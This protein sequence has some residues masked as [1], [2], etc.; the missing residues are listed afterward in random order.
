MVSCLRLIVSWAT[1][2]LIGTDLFV[3]SPLIPLIADD[4]QVGIRGAGL[5]VTTFA[6]GYVVAAP[7]FGQLADR[8]GRRHVLTCCLVAFSAANF[9]TA[10]A[11]NLPVLMV[12]RLLCGIA[13]AGVTPSIYVLV[14]SAAPSGRRGTWISIVLTGLLVSLPLGVPIGALASLTLGWP[15]AFIFLAVCS[16]VLA[17]A[18]RLLWPD[19]RPVVGRRAQRMDGFSPAALVQGLLPTI[20]WSTALYGMY[21]YLGAGMTGLGYGP[22]QIAE[23]VCIYG[24][25]A[26]AGA[27]LGGRI[28]DRLGSAVAIRISL[29]GMGICFALL[30]LALLHGVFVEVA[31]AATSLLA[32][33]FFPAQQSLLL[34]AFP[35][36]NATALAWNNSALFLGMALG[37]LIGGQAMALGGFTAILPISALIAIAGWASF[38]RYLPRTAA[39]RTT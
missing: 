21:T 10:A 34:A 13:A 36:R 7:I 2:F 24:A 15:I 28:A 35:T 19:S 17:P 22:G 25:A 5:A 20:A 31:F 30:Q 37:S 14:G 27:L 18:H 4:Y 8:L 3:V 23:I 1:L 16:L 39:P 26:F 38:S 32:Q 11:T 9:L 6:A 12:A 29:A 33:V